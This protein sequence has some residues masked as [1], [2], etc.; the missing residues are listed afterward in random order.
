MDIE[1]IYYKELKKFDIQKR[2]HLSDELNE[3]FNQKKIVRKLFIKKLKKT[4]LL[5]TKSVKA[6]S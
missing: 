1:N 4:F 2:L 3:D 6:H 5:V